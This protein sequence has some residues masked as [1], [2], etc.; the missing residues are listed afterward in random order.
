MREFTTR[1]RCA[2]LVYDART[3]AGPTPRIGHKMAASRDAVYLFGGKTYEADGRTMSVLSNELWE[4]SNLDTLPQWTRMSG[5]AGGG[6]SPRFDHAMVS[7]GDDVYVF[8]GKCGFVAFS[9][10]KF[11]YPT[12]YWSDNQLWLL[13]TKPTP[14]WTLLN[15]ATGGFAWIGI[16]VPGTPTLLGSWN[17]TGYSTEVRPSVRH[18]AAITAVGDLIYVHGGVLHENICEGSPHPAALCFRS[19][20]DLVS[21][22]GVSPV[23]AEGCN[24]L[25]RFSTSTHIW[26]L[27]TPTVGPSARQLHAMAPL[28]VVLYLHGGCMQCGGN[29]ASVP[30]SCMPDAFWRHNTSVTDMRWTDLNS[31]PQISAGP[32]ARCA[33]ASGSVG[34]ELFLH[35]GFTESQLDWNLNSAGLGVAPSELSNELWKLTAA[36]RTTEA[37]S[38]VTRQWTQIVFE[39]GEA[40][41]EARHSHSMVPVHQS[42]YLFGGCILRLGCTQIFLN[43]GEQ[44]NEGRS[45]ELWR[46]DTLSMQWSLLNQS[47]TQPSARMN[48]ALAAVGSSIFLLFGE[49]DYVAGMEPDAPYSNEF[50]M[51]DTNDHEWILLDRVRCCSAIGF[52][53][54][55]CVYVCGVCEKESGEEGSKKYDCMMCATSTLHPL[56]FGEY[57]CVRERFTWAHALSGADASQSVFSVSV[58]ENSISLSCNLAHRRRLTH[59][60]EET[61]CCAASGASEGPQPRHGHA[62]V[63]VGTILFVFGGQ[64]GLRYDSANEVSCAVLESDFYQFDTEMAARRS[65]ELNGKWQRIVSSGAAPSARMLH[66]MTAVETQIFLY[67]GQVTAYKATGRCTLQPS[68]ELWKFCT[69]E[70]T[71]ML[72]ASQQAPTG[73]FGHIFSAVEHELILFGGH[74]HS[75]PEY[76]SVDTMIASNLT[77]SRAAASDVWPLSLG[78]LANFYDGDTILVQ[79]SYLSVARWGWTANLCTRTFLPC[80]L[81]IAGAGASEMLDSS[82]MSLGNILRCGHA[83]LTCD[84]SN[85]CTG[86]TIYRISIAC[87]CTVAATAPMQV[88]GSEASLFVVSVIVSDCSSL[89][90]GGCIRAYNNGNLWIS[91]SSF[92]GS[93]S[94][95]T[96]GAVALLGAHARIFGS[97]FKGCSAAKSGGAVSVLQYVR[98]ELPPVASTLHV[99]WCVFR[100]NSAAAGSGGAVSIRAPSVSEFVLSA[101]TQNSAAMGGAL[102][103]SEK[104][105]ASIS[106]CVLDRNRAASGGGVALR[107]QASATIRGSKLRQNSASGVGGGGVQVSNATVEFIANSFT[108]NSAPAG[109][110]GGLLWEGDWSPTVRMSWNMSDNAALAASSTLGALTHWLCGSSKPGLEIS[111]NTAM[112]GPC[113][114]TSFHSLEFTGLPT[115]ESPS[116]LSAF[117][118]MEVS[119]KDAY[120]QIITSD[121]ASTMQLFSAKA[122]VAGV[123]DESVSFQGSM[124][125]GFVAGIAT[126]KVTVKP[127]FVKLEAE[128]LFSFIG[129]AVRTTYVRHNSRLQQTPFLYVSG[130]DAVSGG[131]MQT[132]V[133][134]FH[135]A[136]KCPSGYILNAEAA[137][138]TSCEFGKYSLDSRLGPENSTS[139]ECLDCP[140]GALARDCR[141][142]NV[143][144]NDGF[145]LVKEEIEG[146]ESRRRTDEPEVSFVFQ[147]YNCDFPGT[148]QCKKGNE[149]ANNRSGPACGGCPDGWVLETNQCIPC[150]EMPKNQKLVWQITFCIVGVT[151]LAILWFL[152]SWAP[153]FGKTAEEYYMAWVERPIRWLNK[154]KAGGAKAQKNRKAVNAFLSDPKKMKM[155]QQVSPLSHMSTFLLFSLSHSTSPDH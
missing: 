24:E 77:Q 30:N 7:V 68:P 72:L 46:L 154:L 98:S 45:R 4:L 143:V 73:R 76:L 63:N 91:N 9:W 82:R 132:Q 53:V 74:A 57:V 113:I 146:K 83:Q 120:H 43:E 117:Q 42:L 62:M 109:G 84:G 66:A 11:A 15:E 151:G 3:H 38:T 150:P 89:T 148:S 147:T 64:R 35:G 103:V 93:S 34:A 78:A 25:W 39:D 110:G 122:G 124:F 31:E 16:Q 51:L 48:S 128:N 153:V 81:I 67:G 69:V 134:P 21:T 50:W 141:L 155:F 1:L 37:F 108:G 40:Q 20:D 14:E 28:G 80:S 65:T 79:P 17:T 23:T 10:G 121:S 123:N 125:S 5:V 97:T 138:C 32:S 90:E 61:G 131:A 129:G 85:G 126:F 130:T 22:S 145:W 102:A 29:C 6:P 114:A 36:S 127:T 44:Q 105:S 92:E 56:Q 8:G 149:C 95:K 75:D 118:S 115:R 133:M 60:W 47:S 104:A 144:A 58:S 119:K 136:E 87:Q 19:H 27:V 59:V 33:H 101:F 137:T 49:V 2:E 107:A 13:S 111:D 142:D 54:F 152:L 86:I 52:C 106:G 41:P 70:R 135:V 55:V 96:G 26:N 88:S 99:S 100:Q 71:W 18:S 139:P 116:F 112:Y 94:A 140:P 12:R